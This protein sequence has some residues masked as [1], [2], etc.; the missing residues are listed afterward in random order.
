MIAACRTLTCGGSLK[1]FA[2][3]PFHISD[4][5]NVISNLQKF[6]HNPDDGD[7]FKGRRVDVIGR[8]IRMSNNKSPIEAVQ[9]YFGKARTESA[10]LLAERPVIIV[11]PAKKR[12]KQCRAA[13]ALASVIRRNRRHPS[14]PLW[15][16]DAGIAACDGAVRAGPG[17]RTDR[18]RSSTV[19]PRGR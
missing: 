18:G 10:L 9:R 13:T 12:P 1:R 3:I 6:G 11:W 8:S 5:V 16:H 4:A 17:A 15:S 2:A 19:I 7:A 14:A